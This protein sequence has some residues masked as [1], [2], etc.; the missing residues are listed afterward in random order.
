MMPKKK[1]SFKARKAGKSRDITFYVNQTGRH[2]NCILKQKVAD[3]LKDGIEASESIINHAKKKKDGRT[4]HAYET[5]LATL[6]HIVKRLSLE[7]EVK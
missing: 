1:M 6:K 3:L 7:K 5:E 2:H 4:Q